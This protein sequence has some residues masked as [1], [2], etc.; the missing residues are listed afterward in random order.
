MPL[1]MANDLDVGCHPPFA[2][3]TSLRHG[4]FSSMA[5]RE[6]APFRSHSR[7]W[8]HHKTLTKGPEEAWT[9]IYAALRGRGPRLLM[10]AVLL[11]EREGGLVVWGWSV[12]ASF[13]RRRG[14]VGVCVVL[15]GS[16]WTGR[17]GCAFLGVKGGMLG[18]EVLEGW[19]ERS[20]LA[21]RWRGGCCTG[22]SAGGG[23]AGILRFGYG[24]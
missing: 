8:A 16:G 24:W 21:G 6:E 11:E 5:V 7:I 18:V 15:W 1:P 13:E 3:T 19:G 17:P 2:T 23:V 12:R 22:G 10:L 20:A 9:L 14:R 4:Y